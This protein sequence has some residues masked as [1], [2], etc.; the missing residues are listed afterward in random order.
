MPQN[1]P[2]ELDPQ[3]PAGSDQPAP[4]IDV[5][6]LAEKIVELLKREARIERE[7]TGRR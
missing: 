3:V 7:R 6:R 2:A 5:Q 4:P 1:D